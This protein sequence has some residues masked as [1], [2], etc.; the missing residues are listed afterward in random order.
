MSEGFIIL[1]RKPL[2][3]QELY[4]NLGFSQGLAS[5]VFIQHHLMVRREHCKV[6][7]NVYICL[8]LRIYCSGCACAWWRLSSV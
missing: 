6:V 5:A 3:T 4:D 7:F 1:S 8:N 2:S